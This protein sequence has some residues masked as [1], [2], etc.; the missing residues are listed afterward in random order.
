MSNQE[1]VP[2]DVNEETQVV[3]QL[4]GMPQEHKK[5]V[6]D[7]HRI[8]QEEGYSFWDAQMITNLV[9]ASTKV[10]DPVRAL[11]TAT[12]ITSVML[13]GVDNDKLMF[14]PILQKLSESLNAVINKTAMSDI[15]IEEE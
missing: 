8:L 7:I 11:E 1:T 3:A 2:S 15:Q 13:E 12:R 6:K 5:L 4:T 9:L 14:Y 10:D